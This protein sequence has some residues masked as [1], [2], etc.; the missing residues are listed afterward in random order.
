M[1]GLISFRKEDTYF[2]CL[3]V[4]RLPMYRYLFEDIQISRLC[5]LPKALAISL[6]FEVSQ[7]F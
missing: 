4:S 2:A 6:L 3:T 5:F 7:P 1:Y